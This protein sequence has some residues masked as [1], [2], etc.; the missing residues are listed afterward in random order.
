MRKL[1]IISCKVINQIL[2]FSIQFLKKMHLK[3]IDKFGTSLIDNPDKYESLI[4][5]DKADTD[6]QYSKMLQVALETPKNNN[7]AVTGT[8]GSGKSSFLRTFEKKHQEWEYLHISLATFQDIVINNM[9][10]EEPIKDVDNEPPTNSNGVTTQP[11]IGY[12]QLNQILEKSILQQIFYKEKDKTIPFSRFKRINN[13]KKSSLIFHSIF[14]GMFFLYSLAIFLPEKV[15]QFFM[16]DVK[17]QILEYPF[18]SWI[19]FFILVFYFYKIFQYFM[20]LQV[21]K[22]NIKSGEIEVNNKDKTSILNEHLDEILYFFEVT[23][24]NV[25]VIEDLDRFGNTEIFIKL[26]ELNTLINNS[27]DIN[28][29]VVFVYA[30]R[31]D[32]FKDKDRTKFFDFIIPIIPYINSSSSF[33]KIKEKFK[34]DNIDIEFLRNISLRIDDM[35]LLINIA[36]EYKI[37]KHKIGSERLNR[38]RLLAMIIYKNFYPSDFAELHVNQGNVYEIFN[39]RTKFIKNKLEKNK[40]FQ[41][42]KNKEISELESKIILEKQKSIT[43]LRMV[44]ILKIFE[45]VNNVSF[46]VNPT[47]YTISNITTICK[48]DIFWQIVNT[49]VFARANGHQTQPFSQVEKAINPDFTYEEREKLIIEHPNEQLEQLKEDLQS[50]AENANEIKKYNIS[51]IA[52]IE[53]SKIFEKIEKENLLK[54]LIRDGFIR[55]DY[56]DYI[57]Y[58]F[59]GSLTLKDRDFVLSVK[60]DKPL[61]FE[62]L[63]TNIDEVIKNLKAKEFESKAILNFNLLDYMLKENIKGEKFDNFISN[64]S[65]GSDVSKKFIL[66]FLLIT[67]EQDKFTNI[68]V[69]KFKNIWL[70]IFK[71]SPLTFEKQK[72]Y[73][74]IFLE[75]LDKTTLTSLNVD[76]AIKTFIE[77]N[78]YLPK[79]GASNDKFEFLILELQV[80]YKKFNTDDFKNVALI[81]AFIFKNNLYEL[82]QEMIER[83]IGRFTLSDTMKNKLLVSNYTAINEVDT[84]TKSLLEYIHNDINM[85][86]ENVL[87][88]IPE[89]TQESETMIVELL[90]NEDLDLKN[91]KAIIK[92]E[93]TKISDISTIPNE[94]WIDLLQKNKL[95]ANWNN[96]LHYYQENNEL[97]QYLLA[98]LNINENYQELA[99]YKMNNKEV[100]GDE[101]LQSISREILKSNQLSDEAYSYLIK[102]IIWKFLDLNMD[103]LSSIKVDEILANQKTTLN[104]TIINSLKKNFPEKQIK[105][106]ESFRDE[107]LEKYEE[108]TLDEDNYTQILESNKFSKGEKV[109]IIETIDL[110]LLESEELVHKIIAL[111]IDI[112]DNISKDLFDKLFEISDRENALKLLTKQIPKLSNDEIST[113]LNRFQG[114]YPKL[115]EISA[116]PLKMPNNVINQNLVI[117]LELKQYISSKHILDKEIKVNRKRK[118]K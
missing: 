96:L 80:K 117:A 76:N 41:I 7:I 114:Q 55:E 93:E 22:F 14:I 45:T 62:Y 101:L 89:N 58:F 30:I 98:F 118:I 116:R 94:L 20:K 8:Y 104:Q 72:E 31:D 75:A 35:R 85:Y 6:N 109:S 56:Y 92:K 51:Q 23:S 19:M 63:L 1:K 81:I 16:C 65:D 4:P 54:F 15:H 113:Y 95:S 74:Q 26:R 57:S 25:V 12:E 99:K 115:T 59:P 43:E 24:Y 47:T 32:M 46:F 88:K 111:Y 68:I 73:F 67:Q 9:K 100:F 78:S 70:H 53:D 38:E 102:S 60:D 52:Q 11:K 86:V 49:K 37:Y 13:I 29:R 108:L 34:H 10:T 107:F 5:N 84:T 64:L 77:E 87:L 36:N 106:I 66:S 61:E 91:K 82:N 110:T 3:V 90:N 83:Y 44:Y 27:K 79:Y 105:L 112:E 39:Q 97:D 28:R 2:I 18:I 69:K 17:E 42:D 50:L 21:S 103:L 40:Q 71:E 33:E 48:D